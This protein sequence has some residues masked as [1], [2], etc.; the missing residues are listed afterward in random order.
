VVL[1]AVDTVRPGAES[2]GVALHVDVNEGPVVSADAERLQQ[3]F[4]NVLS[5][6][7]KFTPAGGRIDVRLKDDGHVASVT[8]TDTGAGIAPDFLPYVFDRFR[9]ADQTFTRAHGGLGL[10]LAIVKHLIEMHGGEVHASSPGPGNGATFDLRLPVATR[11][12]ARRPVQPSM[13]PTDDTIPVIDLHGRFVLLVDDDESTRELVTTI[14]GQSGAR[15]AAAESAKA[16]VA[17]LDL[18]VPALIIADIGMPGEDGLSMIRRIRQRPAA[19]G[20]LVPAIAL[21]AYARAED[22]QA[23]LDAGFDDFVTKPAMPAEIL[24][25]VDRALT[26]GARSR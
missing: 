7:C 2:R 1:D 24:R 18:E 8:V 26:V 21:S 12:H 16:A 13:E 17:Q 15:V 14:L 5:N 3:V 6:A 4:W 25:A 19:G 23:A 20:A 11:T 9:Q 22:R 10:G